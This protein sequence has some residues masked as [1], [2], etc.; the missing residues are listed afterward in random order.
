MAEFHLW[1]TGA[2]RKMEATMWDWLIDWWATDLDL[3]RL[4]AL[5][6]RLLAD[7]GL[8]RDDLHSRVTA[9]STPQATTVAPP[10]EH[11]AP[12]AGGCAPTCPT[13]QA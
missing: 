3:Q 4:R 12:G 9:A 8:D 6:D 10:Q 5:D 11:E 13:A 2:S 1:Q 7:M